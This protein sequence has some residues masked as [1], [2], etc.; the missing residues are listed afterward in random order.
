MNLLRRQFRNKPS[1]GASPPGLWAAVRISPVNWERMIFF[2]DR[3]AEMRPVCLIGQ[4]LKTGVLKAGRLLT[5]E[6]GIR[7]GVV[8]SRAKLYIYIT[9]TTCASIIGGG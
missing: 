1:N 3:I 9:R 5:I 2:F 7:R 8:I 4:W 6:R